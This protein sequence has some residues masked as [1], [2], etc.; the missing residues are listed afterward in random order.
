MVCPTAGLSHHPGNKSGLAAWRFDV[1][2]E[3]TTG[4]FPGIARPGKCPGAAFV[5]GL[6]GGF[7]GLI[8]PGID[9][10]IVAA[11]PVSLS[12][13]RAVARFEDSRAT[14]TRNAAIAFNAWR[15]SAL[16]PTDC[17]IRT[18]GRIIEAPS[19]APA[20]T[21]TFQRTIGRIP[22]RHRRVQIIAARPI[23]IG[24]GV[25]RLRIDNKQPRQQDAKSE[26]EC[27]ECA[28]A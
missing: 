25:R 27:T 11:E 21:F 15:N 12:F 4:R 14:D 3:E 1:I 8:V 7:T 18:H 23:K 19:A 5:V 28:K 9:A 2:L 13:N 22:G 16:E 26:T 17:T 10:A 20:V 6:T 24:L